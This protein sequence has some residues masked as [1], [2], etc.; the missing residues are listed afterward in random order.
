MPR[1]NQVALKVRSKNAG[2]FWLTVDVF[3]G[4]DLAFERI[5]AGLP[6]ALVAEVLQI[7]LGAIKR[8]EMPE[9]NVLKLSFPRPVTQGD[10]RDR[11]LHGA[12]W[13]ALL[14]EVEIG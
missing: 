7:D 8:F 10:I 3:C 14:G 9:L 5:C 12:S 4:A 1:L 2:P 11:D 13:A 6:S